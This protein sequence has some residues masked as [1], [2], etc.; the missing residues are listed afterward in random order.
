MPNTLYHVSSISWDETWSDEIINN[1]ALQKSEYV[2]VPAGLNEQEVN[3]FINH[4]LYE[5]TRVVP[6]YYNI[7]LVA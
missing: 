4:K 1:N 3:K 2:E 6:W 5:T 7:D